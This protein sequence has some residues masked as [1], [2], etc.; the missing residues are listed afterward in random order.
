MVRFNS[1]VKTKLLLPIRNRD[2]R[3]IMRIQE[4]RG[5]VACVDIP[6][7]WGVSRD[8]ANSSRIKIWS[9]KVIRKN[10]REWIIFK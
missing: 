4:V 8:T 1:I 7:E 6:E 3:Q 9:L 10:K 2:K 5:N